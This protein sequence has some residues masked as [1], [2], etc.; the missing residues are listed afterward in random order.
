MSV[1][2][3]LVGEAAVHETV[4]GTGDLAIANTASGPLSDRAA[5]FAV[6]H[7]SLA[8][9]HHCADHVLVLQE[10]SDFQKIAEFHATVPPR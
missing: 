7:W 1:H 3:A 6:A 9:A 4:D 10:L 5:Q 2:K 8:E